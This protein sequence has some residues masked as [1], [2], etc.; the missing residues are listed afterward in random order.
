MYNI[1]SYITNTIRLINSSVIKFE[2]INIQV[3]KGVIAKGYVVNPD[4]KT[5]WKYYMNL[6]GLKHVTNTDV[7]VRV[8]ETGN[9]ESLTVSLLNNYPL[10]KKLLLEHGSS[11]KELTS[12]YIEDIDYIKGCMYPVD[13]NTAIAA[14]DGTILAIGRQFI[15]NNELSLIR[16]LESNVRSYISRWHI[17]EYIITDEL[18]LASF[19]G[20]LYANMIN[21]VMT[22]RFKKIKTAEVHDFFLEHYFR[23][24]LNI[25]DDIQVLNKSTIYWL[26]K[27]LDKLMKY[28]GNNYTFDTILVKIF[29]ANNIGIGSYLLKPDDTNPLISNL[30]DTS[31]S[32][33]TKLDNLVVTEKLNNK[34]IIDNT[35]TYN[36][37]DLTTLELTNSPGYDTKIPTGMV[38]SYAGTT[39][40]N[41]K[42]K[43]IIAQRTKVLDFNSIKTFRTYGNDPIVAILDHWLYFSSNNNYVIPQTYTDPNTNAIYNL[44]PLEGFYLL[45][46]M[47]L[48][49][50]GMENELLTTIKY[51][52]V[53]NT[54]I[55][56]NELTRDLFN[57]TNNIEIADNI[58]TLIPNTVNKLL[59]P[60]DFNI[61]Y[62]KLKS[63]YTGVW[64]YDSNIN[65]ATMSSGIKHMVRRM[66]NSGTHTLGN[67]GIS[68][69]S[70]I[71]NL[72]IN[73]NIST[74]YNIDLSIAELFKTYTGIVVDQF[75]ELDKML[76]SYINIMLKLSSYTT[77]VIK[78]VDD[79]RVMYSPYSTVESIHSDT[80]VITVTNAEILYPLDPSYVH[81]A[82]SGNDFVDSIKSDYIAP[83]P[84]MTGCTNELHGI[85]M[86]DFLY[87]DMDVSISA[88]SVYTEILNSCYSLYRPH[89]TT[90]SFTYDKKGI[91]WYNDVSTVSSYTSEI[92]GTLTEPVQRDNLTADVTEPN[93]NIEIVKGVYSFYK[94]NIVT[95]SFTYDKKGTTWYNDNTNI[96]TESTANIT[97]VLNP[98]IVTSD[99]SASVSSPS[100]YTEIISGLYTMY[101]PVVNITNNNLVNK[102]S[103]VY[104]NTNN[105][106]NIRYLNN[107]EVTVYSR[108]PTK[109]NIIAVQTEPNT[110]ITII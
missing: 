67:T 36:I 3:N 87:N 56:R 82:G 83:Q 11:Y 8:I 13:I 68:I 28:T 91:T 18:Y 48:K 88:P 15:G 74:S 45:I 37:T 92:G 89:V 58:L 59:S 73:I 60:D 63:L 54:N 109:T 103:G 106:N 44:T 95:N 55:T 23:S 14:P 71:A 85:M 79:S 102:L 9:T 33:Y 30:N 27:N 70:I 57:Q 76:T 72:G 26:Y 16:E 51:T 5:T 17:K 12:N 98:N 31:S 20:V 75:L 66:Y 39:Y 69:A 25:W 6:A 10:T 19:L 22:I 53:V 104:N 50:A 21:M 29:E 101:S 81:I 78:S 49:K 65:N 93:T 40:N 86:A 38:T 35:T 77:Q 99:M 1:N 62:T 80:G 42:D 110:V 96:Y 4:D 61:Y 107:N 47:Y 41:V 7:K 46:Y 52:T 34:Y 24:R 97:G 100:T 108:Y 90:A 32:V 105:F 94:H 84:V 43:H 64:I 2:D